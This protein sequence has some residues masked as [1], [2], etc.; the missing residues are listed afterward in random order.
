MKVQSELAKELA[1]VLRDS[2]PKRECGIEQQQFEYIICSWLI[3]NN[4]RFKE[5]SC[6]PL[7]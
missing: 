1:I 3:D 2:I 7:G 4:L 5:I 6:L